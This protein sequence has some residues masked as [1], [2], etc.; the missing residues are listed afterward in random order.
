[1]AIGILRGWPLGASMRLEELGGRRTAEPWAAGGVVA[2]SATAAGACLLGVAV[3]VV[4]RL[5]AV[6]WEAKLMVWTLGASGTDTWMCTGAPR[7]LPGF[8]GEAAGGG[9]E[10]GTDTIKSRSATAAATDARAA[11][12]V[13]CS[14]MTP[15]AWQVVQVV[16]VAD[17][18]TYTQLPVAGQASA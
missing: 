12:L 6:D 7:A 8:W 16:A 13:R 2:P 11:A 17:D 3:G 10:P 5:T 1:M 4:V 14:V 15:G 9:V 18:D